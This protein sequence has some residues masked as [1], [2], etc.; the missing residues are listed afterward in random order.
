M[1][2]NNYLIFILSEKRETKKNEKNSDFIEKL[3]VFCERKMCVFYIFYNVIKYEWHLTDL[4]L[5]QP[6]TTWRCFDACP[7]QRF[8][9]RGQLDGPDNT[10]RP[11]NRRMNDSSRLWG[12]GW[13]PFFSA[14]LSTPTPLAATPAGYCVHCIIKAHNNI[15]LVCKFGLLYKSDLVL[16][17]ASSIVIPVRLLSILLRRRVLGFLIELLGCFMVVLISYIFFPFFLICFLDCAVFVR[18]SFNRLCCVL[19]LEFFLFAIVSVY[20]LIFF[21]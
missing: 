7:S 12:T 17:F 20:K 9:V 8:V 10:R 2:K 3:L 1:V 19:G 21:N 14:P 6:W 4:W 5:N 16:P 11:I 13:R 15:W 18:A